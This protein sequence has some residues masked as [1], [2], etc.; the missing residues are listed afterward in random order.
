MRI[1]ILGF[2]LQGKSAYEYWSQQGHDITIC[3]KN[4]L[5]NVPD[6]AKT[7]IGD[8]HLG[9]L[10]Q[11]DLIIRSPIVHPRDIVSANSAGILEKVTTN[12]NEFFKVCPSQNIIGVTGTKGKGTTSTLIAKMLEVVFA[13][14]RKVHLGGNIG[15]P[16]LDLLKNNIQPDDWVVLELANFQ[17]IDLK[18][19][20]KIAVCLM[21]VPE[22]LDWHKDE[23]EYIEAKQQLFEH[24]STDDKAIYY[25]LSSTS[26]H[27]ASASQ[28]QKIPYMKHPG[29]DVIEKSVVIEGQTVCS[30]DE[31]R[32][33]GEHNW[34]NVCAALTAFWQVDK[35][36]KAA[37]SAITNFSGL[38]HRLE[39]VRELDGVRYYNDS[40]GTTP[41]TAIVALQAF[42][43]SKVLIAGGSDKGTPF[44]NFANAILSNNVSTLI[45]IG[46]TG[47]IIAGLVRAQDKQFKIIE[48]LD[49]MEDIVKEARANAKTGDVVLL[50]TGCASFGLFKDYKD[51]GDQ[52][53]KA[54]NSL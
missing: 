50:S 31:I 7:K 23:P 11:F 20:P 37:R 42:D 45:T 21:V 13:G 32:L 14:Q 8:D 47:P 1:A 18:Y 17:L 26:G 27:I 53:K 10:D 43:E 2:G 22:H 25:S 15:T 39:F 12:T 40:F 44:D 16:P 33:L 48:G 9:N 35:N 30:V 29:A 3:D 49:K 52:F 6:G 28:G 46:D 51:R 4:P 5:G 54:V 19:S 36:I 24:Q 38:E 41:E 34:Q